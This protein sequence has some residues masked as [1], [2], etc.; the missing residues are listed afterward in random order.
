MMRSLGIFLLLALSLS[1]NAA[2]KTAL[3]TGYAHYA[4]IVFAAGFAEASGD[5]KELVSGTNIGVVT[6]GSRGT[7]GTYGEYF[8]QTLDSTDAVNFGDNDAWDGLSAFTI[9]IL[10]KNNKAAI[11]ST[12]SE[13]VFSKQ[14]SGNDAYGLVWQQSEDIGGYVGI[15]AAATFDT[16][17]DGLS[18]GQTPADQW[19]VIGLTWDGTTTTLRIN[20]VKGTGAAASGTMNAT[21]Q[22]LLIGGISSVPSQQWDGQI[23][24]AVIMDTDLDDTDWNS[25]V[26]DFLQIYAADSGGSENLPAISN[27]YKR[28]RQ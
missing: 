6:G 5:F 7:D 17:T 13:Y 28:M 20:T 21:A 24:G 16:I 26:S 3:N 23:A 27:H 9:A 22:D 8:A 1:A 12:G 25:L 15:G 4:D 19:N 18:A 10:I 2:D 11:A 14:G